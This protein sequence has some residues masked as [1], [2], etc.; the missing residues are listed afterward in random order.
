MHYQELTET[1]HLP[2]RNPS[3]QNNWIDYLETHQSSPKT[4]PD[5]LA[6]TNYFYELQLQD[7]CLF[8]MTITYTPYKDRV[9]LIRDVNKFFINFYVKE[10]LPCLLRTRNIH[11]SA[12]KQVQPVCYAFLDEHEMQPVVRSTRTSSK[13]Q[14]ISVIE[15]PI[16]LHHHAILAV[17]HDNVDQLRYLVGTNTLT[18]FGHKI[19]TSD[20]K[21]CDAQR[22]LY[23]SKMYW[24]YPDFLSFPDKMYRV[25]H[26]YSD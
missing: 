17:H 12:K 21:E 23:A 5:R 19:M 24:K 3:V 14:P 7:R 6:L 10:F 11:T 18:R 13:N 2:Q 20:L 9:Y 4:Y 16:R 1:N 15:F 22:T 26:K 25:R 8:H